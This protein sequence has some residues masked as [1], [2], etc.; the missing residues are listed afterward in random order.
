L[1][2]VFQGVCLSALCKTMLAKCQ[3]S[4]QKMM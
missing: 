4:L 1:G 3:V 2:I